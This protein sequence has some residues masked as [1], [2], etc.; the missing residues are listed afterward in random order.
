MTSPE[1]VAFPPDKE[2]IQVSSSSVNCDDQSISDL[3]LNSKFARSAVP[4]RQRRGQSPPPNN[5]Q[6]SNGLCLAMLLTE[7]DV[8]PELKDLL[9]H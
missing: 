6:A 7:T 8:K 2:K 1:V 3:C 5:G 9:W 4:R